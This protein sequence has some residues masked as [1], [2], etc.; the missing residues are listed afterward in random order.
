M[1]VTLKEV[2]TKARVGQY[3][4]PAFDCTEDVLIRPILDAC[5]EMRSPVI[6]MALEHDLKGRG[7]DYITSTIKGVAPKYTI[8]I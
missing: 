2:L 1:L 3:A 4:V 7:F 8:P 6:L 5:E